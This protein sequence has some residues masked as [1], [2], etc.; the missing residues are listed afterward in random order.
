MAHPAAMPSQLDVLR[1][2]KAM[3]R[4]HINND[5]AQSVQP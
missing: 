1:Q 3:H 2:L 5:A 4:T